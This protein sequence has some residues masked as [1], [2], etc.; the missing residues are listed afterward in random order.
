MYKLEICK[1]KANLFIAWCKEKETICVI[2]F[3]ISHEMHCYYYS[4]FME[5]VCFLV[6]ALKIDLT[7]MSK[8]CIKNFDYYYVVSLMNRII[9]K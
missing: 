2:M 8:N 4:V 6:H 7:V 5:T 3:V 9:V 1:P